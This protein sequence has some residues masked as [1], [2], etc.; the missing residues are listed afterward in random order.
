MNFISRT[1]DSN[2]YSRNRC[3]YDLG[4]IP[5]VAV[6]NTAFG[7]SEDEGKHIRRLRK[8]EVEHGVRGL[9]SPATALAAP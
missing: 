7:C 4:G 8:A 9:T 6:L 3:R 5:S 1:N 2:Q